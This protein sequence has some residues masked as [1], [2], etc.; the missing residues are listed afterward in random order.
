MTFVQVTPLSTL[1][2]K[3]AEHHRRLRDPAVAEGGG[4]ERAEV[5]SVGALGIDDP[6]VPDLVHDG[7]DTH[8]LE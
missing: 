4:G 1:P 5:A 8:S 7:V 3:A 2:V 6:E